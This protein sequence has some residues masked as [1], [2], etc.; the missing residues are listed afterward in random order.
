MANVIYNAFKFAQLG[1]DAT[2]APIDLN[3]DTIKIALVTSSY[4]PDQD[5]D[6]FWST[7]DAYE[8]SSAG[9]D[10]GGATLA[11][12]LSQDNTNNLGKFTATAVTWTAVTLTA[13]G[14]VIYKYNAD[15]AAAQLICYQDFG[16]DKTATGVDFT[17]TPHASG[18]LT[19]A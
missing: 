12:T 14:A 17:V 5:A 6:A 3:T 13:R 1:G 10:A 15:P 7:P 9:Y 18:I 2:H 4:V 8:V 19:L 16:T 11:V